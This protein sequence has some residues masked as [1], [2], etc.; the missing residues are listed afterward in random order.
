[1]ESSCSV[2]SH[3]L[4]FLW[5]LGRP[6]EVGRRRGGGFNAN[7][8]GQCSDWSLLGNRTLSGVNG[9]LKSLA[10]PSALIYIFYFLEFMAVLGDS[11]GGVFNGERFVLMHTD[12]L[13]E[14]T[15]IVPS[16]SFSEL[17]I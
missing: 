12:A 3:F 17:S 11:G 2:Q 4:D 10:P 9:D 8:S 6:V 15:F 14:I 5:S 16:S 1:M 7:S 13:T